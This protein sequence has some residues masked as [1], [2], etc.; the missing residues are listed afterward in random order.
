MNFVSDTRKTAQ[1]KA[2][3]WKY[4]IMNRNKYIFDFW[5]TV[6]YFALSAVQLHMEMLTMITCQRRSHLQKNKANK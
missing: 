3:T 2:V 1:A 6:F 5:Q 4:V